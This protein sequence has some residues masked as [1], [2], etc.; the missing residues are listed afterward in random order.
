MAMSVLAVACSS[1]NI[2]TTPTTTS[3]A[4]DSGSGATR[5]LEFTD[6]ASIPPLDLTTAVVELSSIAFDT[7]D[8]GSIGLDVA[9]QDTID[10]LLDLI[11]PIDAPDYDT[12]DAA[13]TWIPDDDVVVSY[14]DD[15][16]GAWAYPIR[17]LNFHEIVNDEL[18]GQPLLISYCPLCGSGVVYDRLVDGQELSFSNTSA[19]HEFDLVMVDR[20]TGSY[21]WQVPGRGLVGPLAGVELTPLASSTERWGDWRL[22]HPD[23]SVLARQPGEE[24]LPDPFSTLAEGLDSGFAPGQIDPEVLA[25][26]RLTPGATVVAVTVGDETRAWPVTPAR[27]IT[28]EVGGHNVTVALDGTGATVVDTD[29]GRPLP[30][31]SS[32]WFA[33][34]ASFPAVELGQETP[35]PTG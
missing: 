14:I 7:F 21:W 19:L 11:P 23:G 24:T 2:I 12:V 5:P 3:A 35:A 15:Q 31:R 20:E 22:A 16:G 4:A 27:T 8:G 13:N 18:A 1:D 25:D 10:D 26:G 9:D 33:I 28:S 6:P 32:F 30:N 29:T 34:V 17:I